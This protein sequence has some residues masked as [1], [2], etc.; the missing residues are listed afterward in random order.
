MVRP[1]LRTTTTLSGQSSTSLGR[2]REA[3]QPAKAAGSALVAS[4]LGGIDNI[5]SLITS[6]S[7]SPICIA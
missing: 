2:C 4:T 1:P 6:T 7:I 3:S 5:P